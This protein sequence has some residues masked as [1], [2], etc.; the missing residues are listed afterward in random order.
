VVSYASTHACRRRQLLGYF[1]ESYGEA[2]CGACDVCTGEVAKV[3]ATRDAQILLSAI[4]RTGQRFGGQHVIGVVTGA[5]TERI[6][7]F[8]HH[9]LKTYGAG[10][11]RDQR[12]WR[13]VLDNLLAQGL[14]A[15]SDGEYPTL[16]LTPQAVPVLKGESTVHMLEAQ[17]APKRRGKRAAA[18]PANDPLF[19]K[20]RALRFTMATELG[21]PPY[22][23]FNDRT[24]HEMAQ[25]RPTT[26]EALLD[27][28]GVGQLKLE[29][30]GDAFLAVLREE[31]A[32]A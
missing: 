7:S 29:K 18:G 26:P 27:I 24:L 14:V 22:V 32:P 13:R 2:P 3:D 19:A 9:E 10:R 8:R 21:V 25:V 11:D 17:A 16:Q 4:A 23:I 6:R 20:L 31:S 30:F 15:V 28:T 1:G 12:H 5:D